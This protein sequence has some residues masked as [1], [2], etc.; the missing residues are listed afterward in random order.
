MDYAGVPDLVE[1]II[2]LL[3]AHHRYGSRDHLAILLEPAEI[4]YCTHRHRDWRD[5]LRG[6][7]MERWSERLLD[8][9][10]FNQI[11]CA[12]YDNS[13]T[14]ILPGSHFRYDLRADA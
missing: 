9:N 11:N 10:L 14:W 1:A 7:K 2:K 13:C 3:T 4:P 6:L 8:I 12:F 5:N